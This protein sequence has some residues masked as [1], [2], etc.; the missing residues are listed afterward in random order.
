MIGPEELKRLQEE[1]ERLK[2]RIRHLERNIIGVEKKAKG[3]KKQMAQ[4][5]TEMKWRVYQWKWMLDALEG[6]HIAG[7]CSSPNCTCLN[8]ASLFKLKFCG[9][10]CMADYFQ[11]NLVGESK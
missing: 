1:N 5:R 7:P 6:R 10:D 4:L 3:R 8:A 9:D 2:A 11:S